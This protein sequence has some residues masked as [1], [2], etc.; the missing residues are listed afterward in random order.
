MKENQ[1]RIRSWGNFNRRDRAPD[2]GVQQ[3]V[4]KHSVARKKEEEG[5]NDH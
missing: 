5:A 4:K 2:W 3:S 1:R